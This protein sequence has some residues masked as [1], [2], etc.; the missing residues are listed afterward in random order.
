MALAYT[1][2]P[3]GLWNEDRPLA[4]APKLTPQE[5]VAVY[6]EG[7]LAVKGTIALFS[8]GHEPFRAT[9]GE[10][11]DSPRVSIQERHRIDPLL[12]RRA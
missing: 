2:S 9:E 5:R 8:A 6:P 10:N 3:Q 11:T 12:G 1:L 4:T 7:F